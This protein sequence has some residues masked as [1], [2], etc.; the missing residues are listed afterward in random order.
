MQYRHAIIS[1]IHGNLEALNAVLEDIE[2]HA[3]T[4][5]LCLGDVVG[6]GPNPAECL[7][8]A[9]GFNVTLLGNH[10]LALTQGPD[11]FN[12]AARR[13]IEWTRSELQK[14]AEGRELFLAASKLPTTHIFDGILYVHGS[15][16]APTTEYLMPNIA[17]H[18]ERILPQFRHFDR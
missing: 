11:R 6:Y 17:R 18:P 3:V 10:E 5:I 8:A 1:D 16:S 13:A 2:Q 15:P 4:R 9:Q 14:T 12:A 7:R